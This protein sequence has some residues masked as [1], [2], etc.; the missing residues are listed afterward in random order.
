MS[1]SRPDQNFAELELTCPPMESDSCAT[2]GV[3]RTAVPPTREQ[4]THSQLVQP[5]AS[6]M[7]QSYEEPR[8]KKVA[9]ETAHSV[10][11]ETTTLLWVFYRQLL[12][13]ERFGLKHFER[14]CKVWLCVRA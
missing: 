3:H 5:T 1:C 8:A 2:E 6:V 11:I 10:F 12:A 9:A 14:S 7:A 4:T 13:S